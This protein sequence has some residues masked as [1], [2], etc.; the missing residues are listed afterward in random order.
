MRIL[1]SGM[2]AAGLLT[3]Q[4]AAAAECVRPADHAAL[5]VA[6][7]KSQLMV[8]A[9]TCHAQDRY[10]AFVNKFRSELQSEER[11]E[12]T[13]FTRT[14]GRTATKRHDDYTTQLANAKSQS[15]LQAGNRFCDHNLGVF[16]EV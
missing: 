3:N 2:I 1:F 4:L 11:M 7:L 9:I 6:G 15:G 16:D 5:D 8:T 12:Q 14:Y 10:N 13:Y